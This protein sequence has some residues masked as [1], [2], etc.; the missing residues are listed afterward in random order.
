MNGDKVN[1]EPPFDVL[2]SIG[3]SYAA[4]R[5]SATDARTEGI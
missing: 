3:L 4:L 2:I 5:L 1:A